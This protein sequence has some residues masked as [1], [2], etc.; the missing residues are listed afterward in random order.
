M[1]KLIVLIVDIIVGILLIFALLRGREL[2]LVR[3]FFSALGFFGG[4]VIGALIEPYLIG[5]AHSP[6]SR[7]LL[8]LAI[9]LGSAIIFLTVGEFVGILI[10][11]KLPDKIINEV[12][13]GVG[14]LAGG[15][16]LLVAVWLAAAVL[17]A[18]PFTGLQTDLKNSF[19]INKLD[20]IL[21]PAPSVIARLGYLIN[22]NGF[23]RV[24]LGGEPTPPKNIVA[25]DITGRLKLAV[26]K[27]QKSVV[28][29][30]G[31]GCGGLVEGS[32]FVVGQN[33][34]ATNA[35]VVAGISQPY[36]ID[37]NGEHKA[38][39]VLFDSNL[40]LAVLEVD[41][42]AGA[43]LV[44]SSQHVDPDT[45]GAIM[46]YPGGGGLQSD[47]AAVIDSFIATG[48]N[49]YN[50]GITQRQVLELKAP[51]VPGNS[52]GPLITDDGSVIGVVFAKSTSYP[53]VGYALA[54]QKVLAELRTADA[55][56]SPVS[57]GQCAG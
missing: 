31:L 19:F 45:T 4:L 7:L 25:P 32:G 10:K 20:N 52:G 37:D 47:G 8:T 50:Q 35:H 51:I 41:N 42:L 6:G 27:D 17:I 14:S 29:V 21:P 1:V 24:F 33:L 43:P 22:P 11:H 26:E 44:I 18:L 46:G 28:K 55:D 56:S 30:E 16:S 34:V 57:T 2:G 54:M 48:R 9:T 12:D 23:P 5:I 53:D 3:Q 40:D 49:I 36:V 13:A 39:A 15:V 38:K